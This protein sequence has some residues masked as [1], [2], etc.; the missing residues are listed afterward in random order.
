MYMSTFSWLTKGLK[1]CQLV[2]FSLLCTIDY[3]PYL[4][5]NLRLQEMKKNIQMH[6]HIKAT[7]C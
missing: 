4:C 2:L 5:I 7:N 6:V 3:I 1:Y